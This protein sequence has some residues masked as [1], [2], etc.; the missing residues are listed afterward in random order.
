MNGLMLH[1]GG[2]LKTR[3]E[4]FEV[5]VPPPTATYAPLPYESFIVRIEK[6][7]AVAFRT[8][9]PRLCPVRRHRGNVV[10]S[11]TLGEERHGAER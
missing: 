11:R 10:A 7:L 5:P 3:S 6:Q 2:Q 8:L 4:V 1:C 9:H